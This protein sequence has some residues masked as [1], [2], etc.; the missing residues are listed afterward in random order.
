M[1]GTVFT[2]TIAHG[3]KK[4]L[5]SVITDDNDGVEAKC[6]MPKWCTEV[7]M[8]DNWMDDLEVAGGGLIGEKTEGAQMGTL[9]IKEGYLYRY[10][11]RT[12]AGKYI[13][14]EEA[15]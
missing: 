5:D 12:F 9:T 3:L 14:T 10:I 4:T 2:G 6:L 7:D 15:I 8:P 11:A 1:A 13:I